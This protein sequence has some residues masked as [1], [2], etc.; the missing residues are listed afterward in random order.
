MCLKRR[1]VKMLFNLCLKIIWTEEVETD[2][3]HF[4]RWGKAPRVIV[5]SFSWL[6]DKDKIFV[7]L[8]DMKDR[9]PTILISKDFTPRVRD[10]RHELRLFIK[11]AVKARKKTFLRFD[12]LESTY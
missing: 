6:K 11:E 4:L 1:L 3:T 12:I 7:A 10:L 9:S 8:N 2:T 5:M